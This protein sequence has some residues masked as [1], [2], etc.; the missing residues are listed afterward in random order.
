M[1]TS[2]IIASDR[3]RRAEAALTVQY[4]APRAG[5]PA[6]R[7]IARWVAAALARPAT[8]TVRFVGR[9]EGRA[10]NR[11][12]RRKD[13]ATNVLTFV[14]ADAPLA[15]DNVL[16]APVVATEA[17]RD[18]KTPAAHYA[19]LVMHGVLHLQGWDHERTRDAAAMEARE[20]TLL[21]ALGYADPYRP[22]ADAGRAAR[23]P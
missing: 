9:A 10:L 16:C 22:I 14:Y 4:A 1:P 23:F 17:R 2:V 20:T 11:L 21:A 19:H 3:R 6:P 13:Y 8:L 15:G 7:S 5:L 12:Y 18:R